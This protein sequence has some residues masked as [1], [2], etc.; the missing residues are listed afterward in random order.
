M[1]CVALLRIIHDLQ[2]E[3]ADWRTKN[4]QSNPGAMMEL[5]DM[6][7]QLAAHT[8]AYKKLMAEQAAKKKAEAE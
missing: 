6:R 7:K 8:A 3:I 5:R 1:D 4:S 2:A